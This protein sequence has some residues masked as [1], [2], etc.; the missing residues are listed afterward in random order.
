MAS[1]QGSQSSGLTGGMAWAFQD[2]EHGSTTSRAVSTAPTTT[3]VNPEYQPLNTNRSHVSSDLGISITCLALSNLAWLWQALLY[4]SGMGLSRQAVDAGL[5]N[6]V[7]ALT[8]QGSTCD[9]HRQYMH[10]TTTDMALP[11]TH[12]CLIQAVEQAE[13]AVSSQQ[14]NNFKMVLVNNKPMHSW[15]NWLTAAGVTEDQVEVSLSSCSLL[16]N[17]PWLHTFVRRIHRLNI[18]LSRRQESCFSARR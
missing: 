17:L 11:I 18:G 15:Y 9:C 12:C 5:D 6:M 1:S 16:N 4:D 13:S 7:Y 3:F 14:N 2:P 10:R 8:V